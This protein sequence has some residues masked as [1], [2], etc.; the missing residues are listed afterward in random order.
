MDQQFDHPLNFFYKTAL[1]PGLN[2]PELITGGKNSLLAQRQHCVQKSHE[3]SQWSR[4]LF[5][6]GWH[7]IHDQNVFTEHIQ[8]KVLY[9]ILANPI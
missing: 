3:C 4:R 9:T 5:L 8:I 1:G 7:S 6:E 2:L